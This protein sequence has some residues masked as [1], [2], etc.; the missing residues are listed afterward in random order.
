MSCQRGR[1]HL[2][3]G[4]AFL[5]TFQKRDKKKTVWVQEMGWT[6]STKSVIMCRTR[7]FTWLAIFVKLESKKIVFYSKLFRLR[8]YFIPLPT[9]EVDRFFFYSAF[10]YQVSGKLFFITASFGEVNK[11]SRK[12]E[13]RKAGWEDTFAEIA[14]GKMLSGL[15]WNEFELCVCDFLLGSREGFENSFFGYF[16]LAKPQKP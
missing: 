15:I 13:T 9:L 6:I 8:A 4:R 16:L 11:L 5:E 7:L 2:W 12:D 1:K 10:Q 14:R 3:L